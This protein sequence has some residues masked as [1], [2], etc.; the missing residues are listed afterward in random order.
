MQIHEK[1]AI[2]FDRAGDSYERGRPEYPLD[3][4]NCLIENLQ[5]KSSSKVIDL[6][7]GT[8][9]FTKL[10]L[11]SGAQIVAV[12]PV[13]GMRRK[14]QSLFPNTQILEGSAE[15]IPMEDQSVDSVIAAQAFHWFNG[16]LALKEIHRVLKPKGKLGLIWNV[17]DESQAWFVELTRIIDLYEGGAPR[18][19]SMVWKQAF[20]DS[21]FFSN[22]RLQS[23]PY[24]QVGD[25]ETVLDR[26]GSISFISALS[27]A[28]R[29]R[30]LDRV[31]KLV[32]THPDTK[33]SA[34]VRLPYRTDAYWC[35]RI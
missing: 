32:E 1:A 6:G 7:S 12:E 25:I 17:R 13:E 31:R 3:A 24:V 21:N 35:E 4:I 22:L 16:P 19:K 23:F 18:Y 33:N 8:G 27:D 28:E 10:I 20:D 15:N 5:I 29:A 30:A 26:V 11:P 34:T 14:F 2:G 9:K